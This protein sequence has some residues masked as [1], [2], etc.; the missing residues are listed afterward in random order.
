MIMF[1]FFSIAMVVVALVFIIRPLHFSV[2]QNDIDRTAQNVSITKERLNE[3]EVE[4]EQAAISQAEYEQTKQELEQSLL[5]DVVEEELGNIN[6]VNNQSY[7]RVM[8]FI[9]MFSVPALAVSLYMFLGQP[10][11]IASSKKQTD[12]SAHK[13]S[14][15]A[16][17]SNLGTVAELVEKLAARL[18]NQ[19]NNA[20]GWFMLGR[21][22]MSL[23]RYKEA[24]VALEKTNQLVPD[25]P[26]IM[27]RYADA[28]TMSRGGK[29][30]GKPFALIKKAIE[31]KPD[32]PAGLWLIGMGYAEQGEYKKAI[33]YWNLLL[34]L[35]QDEQSENEVKNM[36]RQA[37]RK[38]ASDFSDS[39]ISIATAESKTMVVK[40]KI[41]GR[42]QVRVRL[43]KRLYKEVSK[44]DTVFIFAKAISG[45][46]MPLAV[47]RKQVKD[48]PLEVTL[49][50]SMAMMPTMKLSSFKQV[51]I[52]A[53]VSKS[54]SAKAQSG[55]L[56]SEV[57]IASAGQKN[58]VELN[59]NKLLP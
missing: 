11:L 41:T 5:N 7:D 47:V 52:I 59:I 54:G 15:G 37:K 36:I 9:L 1:W 13:S 2:N 16:S 42:L 40:Q 17:N 6:Q 12:I 27:L 57:S 49:D 19:P 25:N 23:K 26:T 38:S 58:K 18:K 31:M 33:S 35:L 29:I 55:D 39:S 3:L 44:D 51:Q 4:L 30:S 10:E 14:N 53:R 24:V 50:D 34:P 20:E 8:R 32:D 46:S 22:Y 21:S 56:Q 28:L 48:L 43:D 45:S